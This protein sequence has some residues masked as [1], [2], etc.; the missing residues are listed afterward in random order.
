MMTSQSRSWKS[1]KEC[2]KPS[3]PSSTMLATTST[4]ATIKKLAKGDDS[5]LQW[6]DMIKVCP[7]PTS[8]L[9][10]T[11]HSLAVFC[12]HHQPLCQ[13]QRQSTAVSVYIQVCYILPIVLLLPVTWRHLPLLSLAQTISW[14]V[15]L[16]ECVTVN[17]Q[18][19]PVGI[20][21]FQIKKYSVIPWL[22]VSF[23]LT[24]FCRYVLEKYCLEV[25]ATQLSQVIA[26][27]VKTNGYF[28]PSKR[29]LPA[30]WF[31]YCMPTDCL[32]I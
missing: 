12:H 32:Q 7:F 3:P 2:F 28:H 16:Q 21:C 5:C 10:L 17:T 14:V 30:Y 15:I 27:E 13:Y 26:L 20:S 29:F 25:G 1:L 24:Q 18:S 22:Q 6:I 8:H 11:P 31:K 9:P 19:A 23:L 4:N